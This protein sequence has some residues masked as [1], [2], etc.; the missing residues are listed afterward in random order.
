M[1]IARPWL[2]RLAAL[3]DGPTVRIVDRSAEYAGELISVRAIVPYDD[4]E[5]HDDVV[6]VLA[7]GT[8]ICVHRDQVGTIW[9]K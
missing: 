5:A 7:D 1:C 6:G 8:E 9:R 4:S 2:Q 3:E